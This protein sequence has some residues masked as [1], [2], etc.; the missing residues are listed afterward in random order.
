[1]CKSLRAVRPALGSFLLFLITASQ[2]AFLAGCGGHSGTPVAPSAS[3]A[4]ASS[5]APAPASEPA[6]AGA[7]IT[8]TV[9]SGSTSPAGVVVGVAGTS[10]SSVS[11]AAGNFV[12]HNVPPADVVL[13]FAAPGVSASAP[14]GVVAVNDV[15][16]VNVTVSG[17]AAT[18]V[19][20]QLTALDSVVDAAGTLADLDVAG[21]QFNLGSTTVQVATSAVI[22][23]LDVPVSLSD[24]KNGDRVYVHGMKDGTVI[25]ASQVIDATPA[26]APAP[27]PP[28]PPPPEPLPTPAPDVALNGS[29]ASLGGTCPA[30]SMSVAATPVRTNSATV[31]NGR[32]CADLRSGD[33]VYA[34]GP[35]QR[36]GSVLA[37]KIYDVT[38][39]RVP[40]PTPVPMP[41]EVTASGE[42][43]GFTGTCPGV[44]MTVSGTLVKASSATTFSGTKGCSRLQNG[45]AVSVAGTKQTDGS[46]LAL[47]I[48]YTEPTP[49]A[50]TTLNGPVVGLTGTCPALAMSVAG[51]PVKTSA[52]TVFTYRACAELRSGDTVY[53]VGPKQSDGS[54]LAS[55]V[56]YVTPTPAPP[57]TPTPSPTPAPDVTLNGTIATLGGTCPALSLSVAGTPVKTNSATLFNNKACAELKIGDTVYAIG[58]KQSDG[59]VLASK[60]YY[61]N[62][63]PAPAPTPSPT[64]TYVTGTVGS[65]TGTC[66]ALTL[67]IN[68]TVVKTNSATV[69]TGKACADIVSGTSLNTSNTKQ[70]DGS[71]LANYVQVVK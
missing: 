65:L 28:P 58:P 49:V 67:N 54:V 25:R 11:D 55:K 17:T 41:V 44:S 9:A 15:V 6:A 68:G 3:P 42:V 60:I 31:F 71:L 35:K 19:S 5:P 33:T 14:V 24:L 13:T 53:A 12:L 70:S 22:K 38:A 48:V 4:S 16:Q 56:Y 57:P 63:T 1:M 37:S 2:L 66:P 39:T 26:G 47:R 20:Q 10:A 51:T 34:V 46:L 52:A 43:S 8:G 23:R 64:P 36:D 69:F 50:D 62:P 30:L 61:V 18:I 45:D 21:R 40:A 59:S 29:I 32:A 7:T 27:T